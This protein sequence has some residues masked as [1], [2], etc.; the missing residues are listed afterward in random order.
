MVVFLI[1]A[2]KSSH[3]SHTLLFVQIRPRHVTLLLNDL[4]WLRVPER[5]TCKSCVL[6]YNWLHGTAPQ[7]LQHI[8]QP[9]AE[10]TSRR[11]LRSASSFVIRSCSASNTSFVTSRP[12]LCGCWT[13]RMSSSLTAR[14]FSPSRNI[15]R[16]TYLVYILARF[17]CV[18]G[19]CSS[20][21]RL[22]RYN[23][24]KLHYTLH[25]S[26]ISPLAQN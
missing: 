18:K 12:S 26:Q 24:V 1:K 13:T 2:P 17:D 22:R 7:Y 4:H 20:L 21:G 6:V 16:L 11:R 15:S 10:V 9:V 5:I 3:I 25:Y 23:F 14:H 8:T 19:P